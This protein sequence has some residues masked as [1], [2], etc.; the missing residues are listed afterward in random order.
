MKARYTGKVV[1]HIITCFILEK[2]T[3]FSKHFWPYVKL[4]NITNPRKLRNKTGVINDSLGQTH[5]HASS[6]HCFLLFS[7][8]FSSSCC[9]CFSRF[10]KWK[11]AD[12]QHVRKQLSLRAV[13][14][15]WPSGS[16]IFGFNLFQMSILRHLA[17]FYRF[18]PYCGQK[19]VKKICPVCCVKNLQPLQTCSSREKQKHNMNKTGVIND[20]L[21]QT[22]S[23]ASS[24]RCFRLKFVLF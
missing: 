1:I 17:N 21:G 14:L 19:W 20:P 22:H 23:L 24:V 10:E 5:S 15:G 6:E 8:R 3:L 4:D 2:L 18:G 7:S 11:R 13:T 9:F 12:G 16:I